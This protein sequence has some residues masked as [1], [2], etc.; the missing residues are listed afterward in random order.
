[1]SNV[2]IA[3]SPSSQRFQLQITLKC[4]AVSDK[5]G[6]R[7][8]A[9]FAKTNPM[10]PI[11][12]PEAN[13]SLTLM[14]HQEKL[15]KVLAA[16]SQNPCPDWLKTNARVRHSDYGVGKVLL[17]LGTFL[18]VQFELHG[19]VNLDWNQCLSALSPVV[20]QPQQA[21]TLSILPT[22][23]QEVLK[24]LL[25]HL[26]GVSWEPPREGVFVDIPALPADIIE[27][28]NRNGIKQIYSHQAEAITHL[29]SGRDICQA[30]ATGSGKTLPV[31]MMAFRNAWKFQAT[32]VILAPTKALVDGLMADLQE[33]NVHLPQP[34]KIVKLTGDVPLEE[35]QDL[36]TPAPSILI[37]NPETLN[38]L[39]YRTRFRSIAASFRTFVSR[40]QLVVI[41][42]GQEFTGSL[43][44]HSV[45]LLRR[46][47]IAMRRAGGNLNRLQYIV[48]S[49]TVRNPEGLSTLLTQ[50]DTTNLAII[51]E[52]GS[53]SPGRSFVSLRA[54]VDG[55]KM[56]CTLGQLVLSHNRKGLF[57]FNSRNRSKM[58]LHDLHTEL[59]RR[60]Q[61]Q[62]TSRTA[63]YNRSVPA[64]QKQSIISRINGDGEPVQLVYSTSSLEVG[65]NLR[66]LDTVVVYGYPGTGAFR[67]RAGRCGR[68]Q[69]PG[70]VI[71]VP[72][73][74]MVD[75]WFAR[76]PEQLVDG[77]TETALLNPDYPTRML[78]HLLAAAAESGVHPD[79]LAM[80]G[81]NAE[82]VAGVLLSDGR[83]IV[84]PTGYLIADGNNHYHKEIAFRGALE[85]Q[86]KLID[87]SK[88]T[89]IE[90][91]DFTTA[92]R[93]VHPGAIYRFQT[94]EGDIVRYRCQ[95]LDLETNTA[96]LDP[97]LVSSTLTTEANSDLD[98]HLESVLQ[99]RTVNCGAGTLTLTLHSG[100][101]R[102][103]I[104]GYREYVNEP[105]LKCVNPQCLSYQRKVVG[106]QSNCLGCY[107]P[108]ELSKLSKREVS[109]TD[110]DKPIV[111]A[112][113]T[114][115]LSLEASPDLL[116]VLEKRVEAIRGKYAE[117][118]T[119]PASLEPLLNF[120]VAE[121]VL[122][123]F[124]HAL[125][126]GMM[127]ASNF[128][129]T[130]I[131]ETTV[132]VPG[133]ESTVLCFDTE[134]GGTGA[135]EYL[136][137][138]LENVA[139]HAQQVLNECSCSHGCPY[140]FNSL[141][142]VQGN[143]GL[144]RDAANWLLAMVLEPLAATANP[145][146]EPIGGDT[147]SHSYSPHAPTVP[148]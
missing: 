18:Q 77:L 48:N 142:C 127:I 29:L 30:T 79:E 14:N 82:D 57:F 88:G 86:V 70:L 120:S 95:T 55:K 64:T 21:V 37:T 108:L 101:V 90:E 7:S 96:E 139:Q 8:E 145:D 103:V 28:L 122:H 133:G 104:S 116:A 81:P 31:M 83:L 63:L 71:F 143:E 62:L 113:E 59:R 102:H 47:R 74:G 80:F 65:V 49:A 69:E 100:T 98:T 66:G 138:H 34:F 84:S 144:Y 85:R 107:Q 117:T 137:N 129:S 4:V 87:A 5:I 134:W 94:D 67:Q 13:P 12:T 73:A 15:L 20:S 111:D 3:C 126:K 9:A 123:S 46:M 25:T 19:I 91:I 24:S 105:E 40:L 112:Y 89:E 115:L 76:H 128:S 45:N 58:C 41:D 35:R 61:G 68:E 97:L 106:V 11:P 51:T 92:I 72:G 39:L 147:S 22:A 32:T 99:T 124:S 118:V 78:P 56:V 110:F 93:E 75:H 60:K 125:L 17:L 44:S 52:S 38:F 27:A 2:Q 43:G 136:F 148:V 141:R 146:P 135:C 130:D 36:L 140:C 33:Y 53:P 1:M 131:L 23:H 50:R 121:V 54:G 26:A 10:P 132:A 114:V 119:V 42:E 6:V 16:N 109:N